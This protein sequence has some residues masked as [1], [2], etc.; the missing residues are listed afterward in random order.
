MGHST[1]FNK[2]NV[3]PKFR[4]T[5]VNDDL[6]WGF[7]D[8]MDGLLQEGLS[9]GKGGLGSKRYNLPQARTRGCISQMSGL[10]MYNCGHTPGHSFALGC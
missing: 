5:D 1:R 4:D 10:Y 9:H 2:Y 8:R 7:C 3:D 6:A